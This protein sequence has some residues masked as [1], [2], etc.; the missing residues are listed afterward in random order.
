MEHNLKVGFVGAGYIAEVMAKAFTQTDRAS[1]VAVASRR[2]EKARAF[3]E[4]HAPMR[5]FQTWQELVAWPDLDAVYV[6]TPTA[7]RE[8]ICLAAADHKKHVLAEKPFASTSSIQKII[9]ACRSQ[10]VAFMDATHFVHHPRTRKLKVELGNR[11]GAVHALNSAFFFPSHPENNIRFDPEMEPMGA[12]GDMAWYSMRALAE[13][14]PTSAEFV[15]ASGFMHKDENT[16]AVVRG[17]GVLLFSNGCTSTW[18]VGYNVDACV[19]DLE[20]FGQR[21]VISL[22]DFVLDWGDGFPVNVPGYQV[23]FTQRKGLVNPTAFETVFTPSP[24]PQVVHMIDNFAALTEDPRG[25][26]VQNSMQISERTQFLVDGIWEQATE[27][28]E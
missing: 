15:R 28:K 4:R 1:V 13:F 6:A 20:I 9:A 27:L 11:I 10:G 8:E 26:V 2:A 14:I 5:T 21:G 7:V 18:D 23:G 22:D 16:G 12:I 3:A 19:M 25:P 17:A 24:R